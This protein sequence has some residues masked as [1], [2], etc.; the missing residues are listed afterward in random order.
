MPRVSGRGLEVFHV[1]RDQHKGDDESVKDFWND[2][3][4]SSCLMTLGIFE[5]CVQCVSF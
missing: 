2:Y 5:L 1:F 4:G 3:C